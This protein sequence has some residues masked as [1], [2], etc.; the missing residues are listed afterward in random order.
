[1]VQWTEKPARKPQAAPGEIKPA[2]VVRP[3]RK[4][5]RSRLA[6]VV[7]V[8][9][10]LCVFGLVVAGVFMFRET[11]ATPDSPAITGTAP[12]T[13][14]RDPASGRIVVMDRS[15]CRELGFD[16]HSGKMVQKGAVACHDTPVHH[17]GTAGQS[18]YRH[19]TTRLEHI[20]RAFAQ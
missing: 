15:Q 10:I 2:P 4:A 11:K 3:V 9:T 19:P 1:M 12:A 7:Q 8:L 18:L 14:E 17:A 20:R 5:R 13:Q 16:N 6:G